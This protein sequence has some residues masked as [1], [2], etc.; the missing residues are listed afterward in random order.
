[1]FLA[2]EARTR[3]SA[4]TDCDAACNLCDVICDVTSCRGGADVAV[5][6]DEIITV[7]AQDQFAIGNECDAE[8]AWNV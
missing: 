5:D 7:P 2:T 6:E 4:T 3:A 8:F 1:M